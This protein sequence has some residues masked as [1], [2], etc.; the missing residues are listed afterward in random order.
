MRETCINCD[1]TGQTNAKGLCSTCQQEK[2]ERLVELRRRVVEDGIIAYLYYYENLDGKNCYCVAGHM[3]DMMGILDEPVSV[4]SSVRLREASCRVYLYE[5][6]EAMM[7]DYFGL[8]NHEIEILQDLNDSN[9]GDA[10]KVITFIDQLIA[11]GG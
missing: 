3:A 6:V 2:M 10:Q 8:T 5:E 1:R 7:V 11:K 4:G 9:G